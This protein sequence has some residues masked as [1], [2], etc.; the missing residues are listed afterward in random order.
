M[1]RNQ[2]EEKA[3]QVASFGDF[4]VEFDRYIVKKREKQIALTLSEFGILRRLVRTPGKVVTRNQL[5]D[6]LHGDEAFVVD[7]NIDVHIAA[8]RKKLGPRFDYIETVRGVGYRFSD[9]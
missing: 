2:E 4:F 1:R 6:D 3:P 7:R 5:L 9:E 8:L